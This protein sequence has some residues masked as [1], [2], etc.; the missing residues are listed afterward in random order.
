MQQ[1]RVLLHHQ[2]QTYDVSKNNGVITDHDDSDINKQ[3]DDHTS[4]SNNDATIWY[5]LRH[6][7]PVMWLSVSDLCALTWLSG[8]FLVRLAV[9]PARVA[10]FTDPLTVLE[11]AGTLLQWVP[12]LEPLLPV[13][14]PTPDPDINT[15][16]TILAVFKL[17]R[18]FPLL[19][20]LR[21]YRSIRLMLIAIQ[22]SRRELLFLV[23]IL[24]MAA[25][26]FGYALY[27][28]E[29][30]SN[31]AMVRDIPTAIWW[32][33]ITMTTVGYGDVYP[34]SPA[35]KYVG[36]ACAVT[37]IL[38]MALPVPIIAANFYRIHQT[39]RIANLQKLTT[40]EELQAKTEA[41]APENIS[42]MV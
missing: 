16:L 24:H 23:V 34:T 38:I 4:C 1:Y 27:L 20:M 13:P 9:C 7:R 42:S 29:F 40:A 41:T 31:V 21:H 3:T 32:G 11:G 15:F 25:I 35:G 36:L 2:N 10:F 39:A 17:T 8:V 33:V 18:L 14:K 5:M 37:G 19:R 6:T 12:C 28:A 22:D 30:R 26:F